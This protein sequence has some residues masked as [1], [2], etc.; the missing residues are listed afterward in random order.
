MLEIDKILKAKDNG[1]FKKYIEYIRFPKYKNFVRDTK[2]TFDFPITVLV[3]KNGTGKSSILKALYSCPEG[4]SLGDYWFSTKVDSILDN[5]GDRNSLI[6]NYPSDNHREYEVLLQRAPR[7]GNPDYWETARPVQKYGMQRDT[8]D[9]NV[10]KSKIKMGCTYID[11]H[12]LLSAFDVYRYFAKRNTVKETNAYLRRKSSKLHDCIT[13]NTSQLFRGKK[14][15]DTPI[16][17][18]PEEL[19]I[20]SGILDKL[21]ITGKIVNHKFFTLWGKSIVFKTNSY[22]YSEA[23]AGSGE[24]AV[25][26]LINR[27][28]TVEEG[29][30][31][32]LDEPE[33]C[34][35]PGAQ[36]KIFEYLLKI[37]LQKQL[38]I[39][40]STH[41]PEFLRE[42]PDNAIKIFHECDN[43]RI[44]I[45]NE[46]NYL[47][48]FSEIGREFDNKKTI[49]VEDRLAKHII[50]S[51]AKII[52]GDINNQINVVFPPGG[53]ANIKKM[54]AGF[55]EIHERKYVVFDGDQYTGVEL[56]IDEFT[57]ANSNN[58]D[59][60]KNHIKQLTNLSDEKIFQKNSNE[61]NQIII[62]RYKK[63]IKYYEESCFYLPQSTPEE[64]IWD[65]EYAKRLIPEG[66]TANPINSEQNYKQ[67]FKALSEIIKGDICDSD[68]IFDT[69]KMFV[70]NWIKK[71]KDMSLIKIQ[72]IIKSILK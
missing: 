37:C 64:I 63:Y 4:N 62:E 67:K 15:S 68:S 54:I 52:P 2:I 65:N 13:S 38:Q 55:L 21:Y 19:T 18:S 11:F 3:G 23:F 17:L 35:H 30:L 40:I 31:I 10:R 45:I 27:L 47:S 6:Y 48:A 32:L 7:K 25:A 14:Q 33:V 44:E 16:I 72:D 9:S 34:L 20:I 41:S 69:Q 53:D 50:E 49:I 60:L 51:V 39:I 24:T 70:Q 1:A 42:L 29:S 43:G 56:K 26:V 57:S 22:S 5:D 71:G 8:E 66:E 46:C 28:H 61:D 58:L 12:S 59:Y 36:K